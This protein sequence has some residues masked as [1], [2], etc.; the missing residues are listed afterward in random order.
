[1]VN[2][3]AVLV[4]VMWIWRDTFDAVEL[5]EANLTAKGEA[6]TPTESYLLAIPLLPDYLE[7]GLEAL[8]HSVEDVEDGFL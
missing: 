2:G 1:M 7:D 6:T 4:A 5:E 3:G 8:G